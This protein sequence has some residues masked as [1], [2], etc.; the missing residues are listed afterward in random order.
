MIRYAPDRHM[1][2]LGI[3][4]GIGMGKSTTA[5]LLTERGLPVID[6]DEL[7]RQLVEPGQPALKEIV[8]AFGPEVLDEA[9]RLQRAQLAGIVFASEERRRQL[10]EILHPRIRAAWEA[11]VARWRTEGRTAGAVIIPLLFETGAAA[12]FDCIIGVACRTDTQRRRL[13]ERGWSQVEIDRRIASQWPVQKKIDAA[14][15]L[16]WTESSLAVHAA[17]LDRILIQLLGGGAPASSGSIPARILRFPQA[18]VQA[19][20]DAPALARATVEYVMR[21]ARQA[22]AVHGGFSMALSGGSTPRAVYS[23]LAAECA[24]ALPW[25][26]VHLFYGDERHVPP[27]D[28]N[29][30]HRM[31]RETLLTAPGIRDRVHVHRIEAE[32]P[33]A[34]AAD[35]Y[36]AEIQQHFAIV[37]GEQPAFDLVLLGMGTD[38]H[39]ASLFPG[40]SAL[41]ETVRTVVANDV[42]QLNTRRITL[43][44]PAI[45]KARNVVFLTAGADKAAMLRRIL[46]DNPGEPPLP[47]QLVRAAGGV[48]VW[49]TDVAAAATLEN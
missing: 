42:P 40:T 25:D 9:G 14:H 47:C 28:P 13:G 39:T 27:D 21:A 22:I 34:E 43:T 8:A 16:I 3:T 37:R 1:K 26:R 12:A 23:L 4:G 7:A 46:A 30:N 24:N 33:A 41:H 18:A 6:T 48:P 19:Y 15:R 29:S 17:Q 20:A 35:R 38:G 11:E 36:E 2:L 5:R 44:F 49:L 10:E 32:R 31:V 45:A